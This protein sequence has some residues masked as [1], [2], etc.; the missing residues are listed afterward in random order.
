MW[1]MFGI[2]QEKEISKLI[3]IAL[4]VPDCSLLIV[5]ILLVEYIEYTGLYLVQ[6]IIIK[7]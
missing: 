3:I 1:R 2:R 5:H 6:K 4:F 7:S